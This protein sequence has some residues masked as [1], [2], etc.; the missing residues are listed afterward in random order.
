[1]SFW[2]T[3]SSC[4]IRTT[5]VDVGTKNF[6]ESPSPCCDL[7]DAESE[8]L[9]SENPPIHVAAGLAAHRP[10]WEFEDANEDLG[11]GSEREHVPQRSRPARLSGRG[12]GPKSD[13]GRPG[14]VLKV[15]QVELPRNCFFLHG[16]TWIRLGELT[17]RRVSENGVSRR[18]RGRS[19]VV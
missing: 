3:R 10:G 12:D 5:D 8:V 1:M 15:A 11:L 9:F 18:L 2:R 7:P 13:R 6:F 4:W 16:P 19:G 17:R 14:A